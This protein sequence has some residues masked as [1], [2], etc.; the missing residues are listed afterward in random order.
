VMCISSS[1]FVII[2]IPLIFFCLLQ[3]LHIDQ[4][5]ARELKRLDG[6]SRSPLLQ[7]F[8]ESIKGLSTI[9][10]YNAAPRFVHKY[11]N[12]VDTQAKVFTTFWLCSRWLATRVDLCAASLQTLV[13]LIAIAWKDHGDPVVVGVAL[14]WGFQLSGMMQMCVRAFAEVENSA[15]GV[16]RLVA[17]KHVPQEAEYILEPRPIDTWPAGDIEL[18][19]VCARYR[20]GLP[21]VLNNV[22]LHVFAGE[23][24][25]ICGRTGSGKSTTALVLFRMLEVDS[26]QVII[27]GIDA[28]TIGLKD[29]RQRMAMIP[30]DPVLFR[31]TVRENLDPFQ[32]HTDEQIWK[33]LEQ[34]AL[35]EAIRALDGDLSF[36]CAEQGS[37]FSLGQKQLLCIARTLMKV[38]G[39]VMMDEATANID[40]FSDEVIQRTIRSHFRAVTVLTIAH[41]LSTIAD[42]NKI[43]VFEKG[44]L[45]EY[46]TP[47]E[48]VDKGGA[49]AAFFKEAGIELPVRQKPAGLHLEA[50]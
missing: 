15:T 34:V 22:S 50:I 24:V 33:S 47:E 32:M 30:Q 41:R 23:R 5:S 8:S 11:Q 3:D 7:H 48:L 49:L 17:Y 43:A 13:A 35:G 31:M 6:I 14:V 4:R 27:D 12:L 36:L 10:A 37:N 46:G 2:G 45:C 28:K 42:S 26:G 40:S 18:R 39:V 19:N 44:E 38:P 29:L 25:G 9:R 16:E 1:P 20:P 21:L